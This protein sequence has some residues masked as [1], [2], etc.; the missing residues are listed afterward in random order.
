M[1]NDFQ[2]KFTGKCAFTLRQKALSYKKYPFAF[3]Q[4]YTDDEIKNYILAYSIKI[5]II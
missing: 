4:C 5:K 3:E 1:L 2:Y